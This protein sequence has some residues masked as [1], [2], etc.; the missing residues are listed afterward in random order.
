MKKAFLILLILSCFNLFGTTAFV[1]NSSSQTLSKIDF[2]TGQVNNAFSP[3][4]LYANRVCLN[5]DFVYV[6]NSGDNSVQKIDAETGQTITDIFIE[7]SSNPYDM[8]ISQNYAYVTGLFTSKVYKINLNTDIVEDEIIVGISPEGMAVYEN[9]L[10]VANTGYQYPS[11]G[12]GTVSVVNLD[13]FE[14]EKTIDVG[15]NPQALTVYDD[16]I[17]VVCTGNYY[18]VF[19]EVF[20]IDTS[21]DEVSA[22]LEIGGCPTNITTS[23]QGIVYLGD[24]MGA[25]VYSYDASSL[26]ILHS[27]QNPF[28]SGGSAIAINENIIAVTDAG[29]WASNSIVRVY[30]LDEELINEY[31]TGI[32][33]VD[34]KFFDENVNAQEDEIFLN[35]AI[36]GD[37]YPN[38]FNPTTTIS[39]KISRKDAKDA[40]IE[41]YNIKGQKIRQYSIFPEQ[42]QAPYGAGNIQSSII[43]DGTDNNNQ[44]VGS[45]V[46]FYQLKIDNQTV[47]TKKMMLLK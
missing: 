34:I 10:Y 5:S 4:G 2:E 21:I 20:I 11:Y 38:P 40:K 14:V 32:G 13:L 47:A 33:A 18:D 7:S 39:F 8:I 16:E 9:K 35:S 6:V 3:V 23:P 37:N 41:I 28:S 43:W 15:M 46:Y 19:G 17:H 1:V 25:G 27:P 36:L 44:F 22:S 26:E 12:Q 30:N 45:G 31:T 24:G 42:S 29:N